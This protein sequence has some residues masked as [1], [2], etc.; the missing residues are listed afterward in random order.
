[1]DR[2]RARVAANEVRFRDINERLLAGVQGLVAAEELVDF[3]C[4]CGHSQCTMAI[5]LTTS[6]Y[7][8]VRTDARDFV[9]R[10]GHEIPD[11]ESVVARLD[12]YSVVR[13]RGDA[14]A[15]VREHDPRG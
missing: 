14:V 11:V 7:E 4:E 8:A 6:Q 9:V 15:Y 5:G 10:A 12:G 2:R 13:K 3:V 1:M